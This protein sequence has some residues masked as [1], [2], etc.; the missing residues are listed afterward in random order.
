[1]AVLEELQAD[2]APTTAEVESA[3]AGF[4]RHFFENLQT[5][6]GKGETLQSYNMFQGDPGYMKNDLARYR[7]VSPDTVKT[8][9]GKVLS[10]P[11]V[12]L[13]IWPEADKPE[14]GE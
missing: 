9:A 10:T 8:W 5:I 1:M 6:Q 3:R 11:H 7:A 2:A 14:G 12:E 13:H 4:E